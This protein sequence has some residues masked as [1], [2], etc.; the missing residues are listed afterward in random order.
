MS[1][2][3]VTQNPTPQTV[4]QLVQKLGDADPDFRFMSLN[5]LLQVLANGKP[6]FLHHDYNVAARTVDSIIKTLDD[7][8]GEVQN[9]AIK[10]LGPLVMKVPTPIIAP[11]IEKLSSIKLKNSVD[12]AV[13]SLALRAVIM[14]L[15]KPTP[16][17][18]STKEVQESYQAVSRV[19]IPRLLG[20]GGKSQPQNPPNNIQLP[21][22]P[23]GLLKVDKDL[24]AESVDILIEVVR[25]FGTMLSALEVEAMQDAVISLLENDK[26]S[27]VVKK[28]AVV[29]ISIL[30]VHLSDDLLGQL[31]QRMASN[32]GKSE[33]SAVTRRLYISITGSLARSIP[34]RFGT[35]LNTLVPFI[36]QA[37][38]EGELEKHLEEISDGDDVGQDFNELRESA[39][40]ALESFL[41]ACPTEMRPFTDD[42]IKATLRYLKYDPNYA[43]GDDDDDE[44]MEV[45]NDE[46]E[47]DADDEFDDDAGFDDDDDASW[48]VR[49]CAAKALYTLISTR[50]SGDLLENGVLYSQAG[51]T[52]VRRFDERE[53]NVRL[54]V[55]SC[56][57]LL[58]R[59]TGEGMYPTDLSLDDQEPEAPSLIP[60][61]RK[62]RRQSSGGGSMNTPH[63]ATGLTSPTLERI[64][65]TGPRADL[66][67][68]T[69]TIVKAS[70]KLLKGKVI[71]TKQ[72]IIN[73]LDD[74]ITVQRG[75][76]S[77][78]F[79]DAIGPI[80]ESIKPTGASALASSLAASGGNA[81]ATP[82]T[83]RVAALKL[84]SDIAKTH[85]SSLLQPYL[86]KIVA[87]VIAA[88]N[89]RFYK[90]S[91]EAIG[92]IEELVKAITPPRS[93]MTAQK[94]KGELQKLFDTIMDRITATDADAE[95]KQR[96]IHALGVLLSR[97]SGADGAG[98]VQ[99]DKRQAALAAL[100]DRL[101]NETTRLA[102]VRAVDNVAAFS[103]SSGQLET[104]WIREV[105][106]ELAGQLRKANRSL[107]GSSV[108]ALK[109]LIVSPTA[110]G[111]LDANTIQGLVSAL[112]PVISNNDTHLLAPALLILASLVEENA[113]LVV[114]ESMT[115]TICTLLKS[116]Y[117]SIVL[118]QILILVTKVGESGAGQPLMQGL[119]KDVSIEGDPVV[120]GKV[121][122][123]LLVASGSS[124]GVTVES[125]I[126]ELQTSSNNKDDA[127]LSLALAVLGEAGLR[128]GANSPL[129]PDLFL[130]QFHDEPDKVSISAAV[131]LGRAGSGNVSGYLPVI[132]A[133]MQKGGNTQYL[134]IQSIKEIL[135]QVTVLSPDVAKFA[136]D[137]WQHLLSASTI[138]DNRVVC[139]ECV[140]RLTIIDSQRFMPQ[141]QSLLRDQSPDIRG[142]TV[143][144]VRYTLPDSDEAFDAMLK[145]VLVD[146]LLI[147]LQDSEM[148]N[149]RLAM[150]TLNSAAHNK[151]DLILPHLGELMPFV[152][153]ESVIKPQLIREVMMGP[154]KHMVDDGLE[155]RKSAYETLYALMETAFSRINNIDFYDRVVAG[156]KDDNDIRSLCNL[157]VSKLIVLD[158]DETSRRLDSIAEAYRAILSTKLKDGAVKQDVE[159]QEEANKSVLRVTLLLGD[160][161]KG[162]KGAAPGKA[163][164]NANAG[165][166]SQ[167]WNA[168]WEW[169]NKEFQTQLRSLREE[170]KENRGA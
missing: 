86:T 56:L 32:L 105:A 66:A 16:G 151:P 15:P 140:G 68:F 53:E 108:L 165:G 39:L 31:V 60:V 64:P 149:R 143:Q 1:S 67:R 150:S 26:T 21:P 92:T 138:P 142:M 18:P 84:T 121:I 62:R 118:D 116:S 9:L 7:Q 158:P 167:A 100:L 127:R 23:Q 3:S 13:P 161:L 93:K 45:D 156:L 80:I 144:A 164:A 42:T 75:G 37:L 70:T 134:L 124:A 59:K 114:T 96:G 76:L 147:M 102:A 130:Q 36:L 141:L 99:A 49:R 47:E 34:A 24:S 71:P 63:T 83:L 106:L 136:G 94:F 41:A 104:S 123:A 129:K 128:L 19:L 119:L 110:R 146:M 168:Y 30:A 169:V 82:S 2:S 125:F 74:I 46:D 170:N 113:D 38:S 29:A 17:L 5:D 25:C 43:T 163:A 14:A 52:L 54:E 152:L 35:Y 51:P 8:N 48:K 89:D 159:K 72:A 160:R 115:A 11:M 73:L 55:I 120:V 126:S 133:N 154:F 78:Y 131:A 44:D 145:N 166:T 111:E 61:S 155:V 81:S 77:D 157:M 33:I 135:Q 22:V 90:I 153:A 79:N 97:T 28:R 107:R 4:I 91:S 88:A 20:P 58:V 103:T 98:L 85:S 57:S 50:G 95:V 137:I 109:H 65:S 122:G 132:L 117:A 10:C 148:D 112:V 69:P 40:V 101:K 162:A 27:S 12:N 139:A 87:G 6:D